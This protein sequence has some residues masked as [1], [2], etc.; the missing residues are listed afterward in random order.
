MYSPAAASSNPQTRSRSPRL[1]GSFGPVKDH[2][3]QVRHDEQLGVDLREEIVHR[4]FERTG[5]P[6]GAPVSEDARGEFAG[7]PRTFEIV[8]SLRTSASMIDRV[9]NRMLFALSFSRSSSA[10]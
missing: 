3:I 8:E 7:R 5:I 2:A 1:S 9:A 6:L 10:E 4:G